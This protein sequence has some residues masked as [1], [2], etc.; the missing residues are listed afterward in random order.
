[1][2]KTYGSFF[3]GFGVA[4]IGAK[5]AGFELVFAVEYDAKIA[6]VYTQ[7]L[8]DHMIVAD[9]RDLD[10]TA[11][12]WVNHFHASPVCTRASIANKNRGE[13]QIDIDTATATA[14]YIRHHLPDSVTVENVTQYREFESYRLIIRALDECGY[15]HNSDNLNSADFGVPQTRRRLVVRA[16]RG[17]FVPPLPPKV[18]RWIGWYEAVKDIIDTFEPSEFAPWQMERLPQKLKTFMINQNR[19]SFEWVQPDTDALSVE[20]PSMTIS[21]SGNRSAPRA[22]IVSSTEMRVETAKDEDTPMFTLKAQDGM[23]RAFIV[24]GDNASSFDIRAD[25][26]PARTVGDTERV[27]NMPRAFL[28]DGQPSSGK[29]GKILNIAEEEEEPSPTVTSSQNHHN[30]CSWLSQGRVVKISPRG[31]ARFQ[32]IPDWFIL[33]DNK[34][35]ACKGIG[36][37]WSSLMAQKILETLH[38]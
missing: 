13:A 21:T 26:I 27:G 29:D 30:A 34:A 2:T 22:F 37:G 10:I 8:G 1:M 11:L 25:G 28:V 33:P 24:P 12:P 7:N 32:S 9:V 38:G 5:A 15:W 4:D 6:A 20:Q 18:K 16:V 31:L 23:P 3:S 35:L 36:N 14:A 17:G 19:T